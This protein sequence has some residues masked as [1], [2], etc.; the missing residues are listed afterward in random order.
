MSKKS[1]EIPAQW[2][3][4]KNTYYDPEMASELSV[5]M[6]VLAVSISSAGNL[7]RQ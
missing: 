6:D 7:F 2:S 5:S 4:A 1:A 3:Y